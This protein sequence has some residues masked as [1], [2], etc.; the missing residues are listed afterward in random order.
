MRS[1][2]GAEGMPYVFNPRFAV[3]ALQVP[4]I[5]EV[6]SGL[7]EVG[8]TSCDSKQ[9]RLLVLGDGLL[10]LSLQAS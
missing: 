10:T 3:H 2:F 7:H 9:E 4:F 1:R 5:H 6:V 8:V